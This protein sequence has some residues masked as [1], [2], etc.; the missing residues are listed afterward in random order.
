MISK[1][2]VGGTQRVA[3][4]ALDMFILV[5]EKVDTIGDNVA[6]SFPRDG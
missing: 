2:F 4:D 1:I 5:G 3:L 6:E